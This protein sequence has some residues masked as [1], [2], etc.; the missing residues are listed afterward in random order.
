VWRTKSSLSKLQKVS[1]A[2]NVESLLEDISV[3]DAQNL[4]AGVGVSCQLEMFF[5]FNNMNWHNFT[6]NGFYCKFSLKS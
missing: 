4:E 1:S 3:N 6:Q 2:P 5:F